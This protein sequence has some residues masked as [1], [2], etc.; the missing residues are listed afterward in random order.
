[1]GLLLLLAMDEP[2]FQVFIPPRDTLL[3]I[4]SGGHW[5]LVQG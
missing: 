4:L 3:N 5:T 1:M 2:F